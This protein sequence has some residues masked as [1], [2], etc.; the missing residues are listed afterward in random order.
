[1]NI[2]IYCNILCLD[3]QSIQVGLSLSGIQ[4][5]GNNISC[6][7]AIIVL[8]GNPE[9][10]LIAYNLLSDRFFNICIQNKIY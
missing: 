5:K 4:D 3:F 8:K 6:N 10:E 2:K 7:T 1:M 9:L